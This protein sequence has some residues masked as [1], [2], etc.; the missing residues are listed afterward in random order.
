[1]TAVKK[2]RQIE[3]EAFSPHFEFSVIDE[4]NLLYSSYALRYQVYCL[5]KRFL[6]AKDYPDEQET[7][8]FDNNS[9]HVGC[10][11]KS[12]SL[13]GTLR[14]VLPS[15]RGFPLF[16]HCELFDKYKNLADPNNPALVTAAELS[17]LAIMKSRRR[18]QGDGL[19]GVV[20][21]HDSHNSSKGSEAACHHRHRSEIV[22]G[23]YK[24]MYQIS[25]R[26]GITHWFVAIE[27]SLLR[28]LRRYK[29]TFEPIGPE[30]DYY[31][32]VTPYMADIAEI[33]KKVSSECPDLFNEFIAGLEPEYMPDIACVA[34]SGR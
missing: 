22:L 32:P 20:D 8:I 33:E 10:T 2:A 3:M 21:N 15:H 30:V 1:M 25:K 24:A 27:R 19:Y 12:D 9:I 13:I 7:D 26:Q 34:D 14:L 16:E 31:G 17:R 28:L 5:E 23:L 18:R 6:S 4:E 11:D 29:F